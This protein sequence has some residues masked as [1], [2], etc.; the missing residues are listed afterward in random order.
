MHWTANRCIGLPGRLPSFAVA[1]LVALVPAAVARAQGR[2]G[3]H[4]WCDTALSPVARADMVVAAMT[5]VE[6][7]D[8]LG[9][10][11]FQ[12]GTTSGPDI[13]TGVQDGVPRLDVPTVYYT[14]GPLGPRQGPST[15][16][17]APLGLAATFSPAMAGLY[18]Q[19]V[20][21][22][23]RD[24]G[25]DAVFGPT[26]NI[27]RTP[28]GGRTYEAFG[29]DPFLTSAIAVPWIDG[30]QA[31]GVMADVKH[32]AE[33]NQEGED[34]TGQLNS[35]GGPLGVGVLSPRYVDDVVV[36][37]R[38][39]H[40]IELPAFQAAVTQAHVATVMCSYNMV[41]GGY[42]CENRHLLQDILRGQWGFD[43]YVIADYGAA[44][45][46]IGSLNNGLD[47]EPWPPAAY[48]PLEIDAALLAGQVSMATIDA[49]VR[50][51]LA[52]WFRSGVFDRGAY[53]N[54]DAQ[55]DQAAHAQDAVAIEQQ[56]TTLLR[57]SHGLLPLRASRLRRI[58]VIGKA[59][60]TFITG[61]GSGNV[62][63]FRF[64]SLLAGIRARVG[65]HVTVTYDDGS[66]VAAAVAD[67]RAAGVAIV[68]A[69]DY[70]TEGADRSCLTLECPD[71]NGDQDGLIGQVAA[72][73]PRTA[74]VLE[75]GGPDLTPWRNRVGAL[76]ETWYPGGPGGAAVAGVLF[77]DADPG[78]RLPVTFPASAGQIPTAGTP[79]QYPGIG[80]VTD[81]SEGVLVGYRWYDAQHEQPAYPFGFGLSYTSFRLS[82]LRV[83]RRPGAGDADTVAVRVTNTGARRGWAVPEVYVA[84]PAPAG[85]TEPPDQLKGFAKLSLAPHQ[86]RTATIALDAGS[87]SYW[88][89]GVQNWSIQPGCDTILVGTSSRN[90]PLHTAVAQ[91]GGGCPG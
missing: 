88:S 25:N 28:L 76:L 46:T 49:H 71:N 81:Y 42:A 37:D 35:P 66:D 50:D 36:D 38:T 5:T 68:D 2:C 9:G 84:V 26:V 60:N 86:T 18:G 65:P 20:A 67:A 91:A 70:Y 19:V 75:S 64:T 53:V 34:P 56:A 12:G 45:N 14:D 48:Q 27:M 39:L 58:A 78:G 83:H 3:D 82:H 51:T 23:A 77:G 15:G 40:E 24:K 80:P 74:V 13:H 63:A 85:L 8:F 41:N 11:S 69:S 73:N 1:F 79:A 29:E 59:A 30:A 33:N 89:T 17:P 61:G 47:F 4:P 57:N 72:A 16:M 52:Q 6:K 54:D 21:N 10:D 31:Q 32:F 55:I 43:G 44:H 7:V 90:L 22:E 62:T 87:F